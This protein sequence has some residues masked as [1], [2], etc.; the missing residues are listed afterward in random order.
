M[1]QLL[2]LW[3][4]F[5]TYIYGEQRSLI[6]EGVLYL[7]FH[8]TSPAMMSIVSINSHTLWNVL[9]QDSEFPTY[10]LMQRASTKYSSKNVVNVMQWW[11]PVTF[12]ETMMPQDAALTWCLH[13][14]TVSLGD[15]SSEWETKKNKKVVRA[16]H[17]WHS[18]A[19]L[20]TGRWANNHQEQVPFDGQSCQREGCMSAK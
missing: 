12:A 20:W 4:L 2:P 13:R 7:E 10:T 14:R 17:C 19:A 9:E 15:I 16:K 5:W 1:K 11:N 6:S 3:M 8:R 18:S